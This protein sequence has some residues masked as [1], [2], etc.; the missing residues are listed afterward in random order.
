MH[1]GYNVMLAALAD[2]MSLTSC[3]QPEF[4]QGPEPG[5]CM[6]VWGSEETVLKMTI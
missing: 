3:Y 6:C 4:W 2:V 1:F 5:L